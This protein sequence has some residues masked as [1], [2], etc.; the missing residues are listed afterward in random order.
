LGTELDD[1]GQTFRSHA[2]VAKL[3]SRGCAVFR[4]AGPENYNDT[5]FAEFARGLQAETTIAASNECNLSIWF[6]VTHFASFSF[7]FR[8]FRSEV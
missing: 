8:S 6:C 2:F 1:K 3:R 7:L 4:V 5:L